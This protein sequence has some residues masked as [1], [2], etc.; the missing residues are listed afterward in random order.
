MIKP[1]EL[2]I[3]KTIDE[4]INYA[5]DGYKILAGGTDILVMMHKG[6][7][8][9]YL[10]D[11]SEIQELKSISFDPEKGLLIGAC[12][13]HADLENNPYVK[14]FFPALADGCSKIGSTQVRN[15]GTIGGNICNASPAA[16]SAGPLMLYD[17]VVNVKGKNGTRTIPI[18]KFF[19]GV[20]KNVLSR[21]EIVVSI[22]LPVNKGREG[23]AY[24]KLMKRGA[25]EIG[26]MS[27]GIRIIC[28]EEGSCTDARLTLSA[29]APTPIRVREA[30]AA[31]IGERISDESIGRAAGYAYDSATPH[32]WR[33]SEEWSKDMVLTYVPRAAAL[34]VKRMEGRA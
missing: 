22:S 2:A 11:I 25:M 23:S 29:V 10:L 16:D 3:A 7:E 33:N 13:T 20:K 8:Y 12:A 31:L 18:E 32:T 6:T 30:E 9:P 26:I 28:D 17:A 15:R 5:D 21:D 24:L 34:A 27:V 4:A 19:T 1:F 14:E